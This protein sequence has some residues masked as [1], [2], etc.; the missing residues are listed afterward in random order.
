MERIQVDDL[1]DILCIKNGIKDLVSSYVQKHLDGNTDNELK[2]RVTSAVK[3]WIDDTFKMCS[4]NLE[5]NGMTYDKAL[6]EKDVEPFDENL[7]SDLISLES[8]IDV[9]TLRVT[10]NR[11]NSPEI[12]KKKFEE[13][14]L[15]QSFM[16]N[17]AA[18]IDDDELFP[19]R[20]VQTY[21][22]SL[23]LLTELKKSTTANLS[24][25]ERA[26]TVVTD[27]NKFNST[28]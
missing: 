7:L 25:F 9:M 22:R 26:Q 13:I 16:K 18:I 14:L 6:E 3:K 1:D 27:I 10:E 23:C 17:H 8:D 28:S 5:V 12:I 15:L 21:D 19:D 4:P 11:R 2:S 20:V 24:R